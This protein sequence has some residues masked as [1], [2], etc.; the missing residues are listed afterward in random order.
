MQKRR[1]LLA[2]SQHLFGESL[3]KILRSAQD[4]DLIGPCEL[5]DDICGRIAEI[6]PD[7]VLVV[8]EDPQN[9]SLIHLTTLIMERYPELSVMRADLT[10][11]VVRVFSTHLLPARGT[12]LLQTIRN[13]PVRGQK[14]AADKDR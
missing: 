4:I 8:D 7:S 12:D 5:N 9:D 10:E 14:P 2:C 1:I 3:E 13:L 6:H 11:N